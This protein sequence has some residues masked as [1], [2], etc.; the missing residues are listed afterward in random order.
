MDNKNKNK[1]LF[2]ANAY[3]RAGG[4]DVDYAP[5]RGNAGPFPTVSRF[6][7]MNAR[8]AGPDSVEDVMNDREPKAEVAAD[9]DPAEKARARAAG[10]PIFKHKGNSQ[11][12]FALFSISFFFENFEHASPYRVRIW[13]HSGEAKTVGELDF[14]SG[15]QVAYE[16]P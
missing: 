2:H 3:E 11:N 7:S 9:A 1:I 4:E 15:A 13:R 16:Y 8:R 5:G 12:W 6:A 10:A 14:R